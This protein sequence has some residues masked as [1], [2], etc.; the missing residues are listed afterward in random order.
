[1]PLDRIEQVT[2]K[3]FNQNA[4]L[5]KVDRKNTF[6]LLQGV[7]VYRWINWVYHYYT[8]FNHGVSLEDKIPYYFEQIKRRGFKKVKRKEKK[9][10]LHN[11]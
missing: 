10:C 3:K 5:D 8:Y 1:M 9:T 4:Y 2:T 7:K 6:W 11:I